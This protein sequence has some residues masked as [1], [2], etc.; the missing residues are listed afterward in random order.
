MVVQNT[1]ALS[2]DQLAQRSVLGNLEEAPHDK[3][4]LGSPTITGGK[5]ELVHLVTLEKIDLPAPRGVWSLVKDEDGFVAAVDSESDEVVCVEDRQRRCLMVGPRGERF[6]SEQL[7]SGKVSVWSIFE[8]QRQHA[9]CTVRFGV[10]PTRALHTLDAAVLVWPRFAG[11]R[12]YWKASCL[13]TILQLD[14]YRSISSKWVSTSFKHW[15]AY[16]RQVGFDEGQLI[17][18]TQA[19]A[20]SPRDVAS[21]A[22]NF[23]PHAS[24]STACLLHLLCRWFSCDPNNGG[25]RSEGARAC[26]KCLLQGLLADTVGGREFNLRLTFDDTYVTAWPFQ[27]PA[28]D[29]VLQVRNGF[30]DMQPIVH[31][32]ENPA[33]CDPTLLNWWKSW[34]VAGLGSELPLHSI[35][36]RAMVTPRS[37]LV[38]QLIVQVAKLVDVDILRSLANKADKFNIKLDASYCSI[39]DVID[40]PDQRNSYLLRHVDGGVRESMKHTSHTLVNDKGAIGGLSLDIGA[41][42]W[43]NNKCA[44]VVPQ[45]ARWVGGIIITLGGDSV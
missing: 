5:W 32:V 22:D 34:N 36:L 24:M 18:S 45:V 19:A 37:K 26:A 10:G 13:Y 20:S 42:I 4:V 1:V 31:L 7:P 8:K 43:P 2:S 41:F 9:T 33:T 16:C 11:S 21:D 39:V 28:A 12:V 25:L 27:G 17:Q 6:V 14:S 30:I 44:I 29:I 3:I 35:L 38:G 15:L 23:L 40:R